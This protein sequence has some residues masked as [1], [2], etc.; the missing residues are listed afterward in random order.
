MFNWNKKYQCNLHCS[1][2]HLQKDATHLSSQPLL[3]EVRLSKVPLP[4]GICLEGFLLQKNSWI[5]K[6]GF[7]LET[8]PDIGDSCSPEP[9]KYQVMFFTRSFVGGMD[10][11]AAI[12]WPFSPWPRIHLES[13]V[14]SL[15]IWALKGLLGRCLTW[16]DLK[17]QPKRPTANN[18]KSWHCLHWLF[19][20][21]GSTIAATKALAVGF[22]QKANHIPAGVR[23]LF[24]DNPWQ[25]P[26]DFQF[27]PLQGWLLLLLPR[28]AAVRHG[29]FRLASDNPYNGPFSRLQTPHTIQVVTFES[30]SSAYMCNT[31]RQKYPND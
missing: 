5:S 19:T 13:A 22:L 4:D 10:G 28:P 18:D 30:L 24:V 26:V 7:M 8:W 3:G 25:C 11:M 17:W 20:P 31:Q 29:S 21:G 14:L 9:S 6:N 2:G 1:V 15:G 27:P 12:R 16:N 23:Y